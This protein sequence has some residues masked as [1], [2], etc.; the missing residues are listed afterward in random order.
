MKDNTTESSDGM[1]NEEIWNTLFVLRDEVA[2]LKLRAGALEEQIR[3]QEKHSQ[4]VDDWLGSLNNRVELLD[5]KVSNLEAQN[6]LQH[7]ES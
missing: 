1:K 4:S 2:L 7:D 5:I 3:N 6:R